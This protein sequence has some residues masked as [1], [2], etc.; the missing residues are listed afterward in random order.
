MSMPL[1]VDIKNYMLDKAVI[2]TAS[3]YKLILSYDYY[4]DPQLPPLG[5]G[6]FELTLTKQTDPITGAILELIADDTETIELS[7]IG[8]TVTKVI[9]NAFRIVANVGGAVNIWNIEGLDTVLVIDED[10]VLEV[11]NLELSLED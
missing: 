11:E 9:I 4:D 7:E 10:S 2:D 8:A 1:T 6:E 3:A 5:A